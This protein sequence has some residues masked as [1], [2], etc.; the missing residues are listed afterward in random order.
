MIPQCSDM[1]SDRTSQQSESSSGP[2]PC[3]CK[4]PR[5]VRRKGEDCRKSDVKPSHHKTV[6]S[7]HQLNGYYFG[8]ISRQRLVKV[9]TKTSFWLNFYMG[10]S[11]HLLWYIDTIT[12][13]SEMHISLVGEES[14]ANCFFIKSDCC[15]IAMEISLIRLQINEREEAG[16]RNLSFPVHWSSSYH[17]PPPLWPV[18]HDYPPLSSN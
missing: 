12:N 15:S 9:K 17:W 14:A 1:R 4:I 11:S 3:F 18:G 2:V 13:R 16:W 8:N 6:I 10:N 5:V 7:H